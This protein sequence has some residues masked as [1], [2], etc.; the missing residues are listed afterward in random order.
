MRS[1]RREWKRMPCDRREENCSRGFFGGKVRKSA[2]P[3]FMPL[4]G[5]LRARKKGKCSCAC[6]APSNA[7]IRRTK[8][9]VLENENAGE[10][11]RKKKLGEKN[12]N[13]KS[14]HNVDVV[15][16]LGDRRNVDGKEMS[17][18]V[19]GFH[20][21]SMKIF[22]VIRVEERLVWLDRLSVSGVLSHGISN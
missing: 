22:Y 17:W 19:K 15:W 14:T 10:K 13:K 18:V 20:F 3:S 4:L 2:N 16:K 8:H 12:F 9:N 7:K 1:S 21:D 11:R 5:E 6:R